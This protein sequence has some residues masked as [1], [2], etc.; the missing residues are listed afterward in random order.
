M[1]RKT[2]PAKVAN[3]ALAEG[4]RELRKGSRTSPHRNRTR[5]HRPSAKRAALAA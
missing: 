1:A 3:P 4:M 2:R 5:Y